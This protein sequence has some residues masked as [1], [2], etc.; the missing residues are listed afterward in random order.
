[1]NKKKYYYINIILIVFLLSTVNGQ[2]C[3]FNT[4]NQNCERIYSSIN[5]LE[6]EILS[7]LN[8]FDK[9]EANIYN[10][11]NPTNKLKFDINNLNLQQISPFL[12]PGIYTF[13]ILAYDKAGNQN[14]RKFEYIFDNTQP[15]GP[16]VPTQLQ[17]NNTQIIVNGNTTPNTQVHAKTQSNNWETN[18][19]NDGSF[20]FS[21]N[22]A[23]GINKVDFYTQNPN[24][25]K[26]QTIERRIIIG[27]YNTSQSK[28]VT[29]INID[30]LASLNEN[31]YQTFTSKRNLYVQG[32]ANA[33]DGAIVYVNGIP[34]VVKNNKYA[35]F[36]L[37][38]TGNNQIT[39]EKEDV[40]KTT[41][42]TYVDFKFQFLE[43]DYKKIV[44]SS[45]MN[46]D[47]KVTFDYPFLVFLNGK[48]QKK[49]TPNNEEF[50]FQ[51][52]NLTPGKNFIEIR[53]IDGKIVKDHIY[54]D[55][56]NPQSELISPSSISSNSSITFKLTDDIGINVSD[57]T[58]EVGNTNI[59][60]ENLE[61]KDNFYTFDLTGIS[62]GNHQYTLTGSDLSGKSFTSTGTVNINS[63]NTL[64][65]N[66]FLNN[67]EIIGNRI[68]T[69]TGEI[70]ITL[71]PTKNIAF[72]SIYLDQEEQ[73]N[74]QILNN[75]NIELTLNIQE[76]SGE[77]NLEFID[78][79]YNTLTQTFIYESDIL[80]P[81]IELDYIPFPYTTNKT[82]ITGVINDT[83]FDWT[84]LKFNNQNN[85]NRYGNYFEA[86]I[87][88]NSNNLN[89][90]GEDLAG[91]S[92]T[93]NYGNL[94]HKD[95]IKT[96]VNLDVVNKY[97]FNNFIKGSMISQE[98]NANSGRS[99]LN[100]IDSY[101]G[102]KLNK[103]YI[104]NDEFQLPAQ[105][106]TGYRSL[107]L[108]GYEESFLKFKALNS[109]R[110]QPKF[111]IDFN[112]YY[113]KPKIYFNGND[114]LTNNNQHFVQ[115]NIISDNPIENVNIQGQNCLFD[116]TTFICNVDLVTGEN[117]FDVSVTTTNNDNNNK[118]ITIIKDSA[119]LNININDIYGD[120]LQKSDKYYLYGDTIRIN[121]TTNKK[122]LIKALINSQEI[123]FNQQENNFEIE[124][125]V[126]EFVDGND[127]IELNIQLEA[128]TAQGKTNNSNIFLVFYKRIYETFATVIIQ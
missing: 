116:N 99:I 56:Q 4:Y 95:N 122:A 91:N 36:V 114:I 90:I 54:Y 71:I 16:I 49:I 118:T 1:M 25:I 42:I 30:N 73:T 112:N 123:F 13:E 70:T 43:M 83:N 53:G 87:E 11:N 12:S 61:V 111:D 17:S 2:D 80:K 39:V 22:L 82:K 76:P 113:N 60:D 98:N 68:Y 14:N 47:G 8:N 67:G 18:S 48:Y 81:T 65:K 86:I 45:T 31:T 88:V 106:I 24:G 100:F 85:F 92:F 84:S 6:V 51:I 104:S 94:I 115:G 79:N 120:D 9:I 117:I 27:P 41:N 37:L 125:D 119:P 63:Q 57:I 110:I 124:V 101:D 5:N 75:N 40:V 15:I 107:N 44:Q 103:V 102:F 108:K 28:P 21:L 74:Y 10:T 72:K 26:S 7:N 19:N 64:I 96:Q 23:D 77:L 128:E 93:K 109:F 59:I 35:N 33:P 20:T 78:K 58:L 46:I 55:T 69:Q 121:A 32:S 34:T 3:N 97:K 29:S 89:I 105:D 62:T 126:S 127:E 50:D 38:N 66:I 52:N